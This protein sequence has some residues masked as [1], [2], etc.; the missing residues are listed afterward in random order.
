[1]LSQVQSLFLCILC[2]FANL[3]KEKWIDQ[4]MEAPVE[5]LHDANE[6]ME[7]LSHEAPWFDYP[8]SDKEKI[9]AVYK[10]IGE[11]PEFIAPSA[12]PQLLR[13][14]LVGSIL[15]ILLF[16][17]FQIVQVLFRKQRE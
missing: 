14:I 11:K 9:L 6:T 17:V 15:L 2:N 3:S 1:M 4:L 8:D 13:Y 16:F 10:F 12:F 5:K 7:S